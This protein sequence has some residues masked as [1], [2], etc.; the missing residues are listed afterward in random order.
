MGLFTKAKKT[1]ADRFPAG[2]AAYGLLSPEQKRVLDDFAA[3]ER[4]H[5]KADRQSALQRIAGNYIVPKFNGGLTVKDLERR[6]QL[7]YDSCLA[8]LRQ[9]PLTTNMA[10]GLFADTAFLEGTELKTI[11]T[12][13]AKPWSYTQHRHA[14]E[15]NAFGFTIDWS[16]PIRRAAEARPLYAGLNFTRH[17][18]GAAP[19]YGS[20]ALVFRNAVKDR[21]TFINTDT[22]DDSFKFKDGS[23]DVIAN[24]RSKICTSAQMDT[25]LANISI[26]QLKALCQKADSCYVVDDHP[27]NYI[28]A[29]VFGGIQWARDL[30]EIAICHERFQQEMNSTSLKVP[31]DQIERNIR[32]FATRHGVA[33]RVYKLTRV[34]KTIAP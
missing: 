9:A 4:K 30:M 27:P 1:Y 14:V 19:A 13:N 29:H 6:A 10:A 28:E 20:V 17:P 12:T 16:V 32:D 23:A 18:Y 2:A 33:A 8:E 34:E 3:L 5:L 22:F 11:F 31:A 21:C 25:L 24:S 26:N 7:L 15:S